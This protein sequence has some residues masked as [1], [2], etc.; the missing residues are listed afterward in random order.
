MNKLIMAIV[1]LN[2]TVFAGIVSAET[3]T[4]EYD[5]TWKTNGSGNSGALNWKV[6]W[7]KQGAGWA[8]IGD[9]SDRYGASSFNGSC[10][11]ASCTLTQ[12]YSSGSL[13]GKPYIYK[14]N[15]T[16]KSTGDGTSENTFTG[17]WTGNGNTGTWNATAECA[18]N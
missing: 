4:C 7:V 12:T 1:V 15:Y 17:T 18:R 16:D 9:M 13:V 14:G 10:T 8:M 11:N 5:G 3:W 6:T 2:L